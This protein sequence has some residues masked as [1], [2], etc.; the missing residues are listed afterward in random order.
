MLRPGPH[1]LGLDIGRDGRLLDE[2]GV[3]ARAIHVIGAA[4]RGVEW[5]VAAIPDIRRQAKSVAEALRVVP[6]DI[7]TLVG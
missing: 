7:G 4:R 1:G 3:P 5:E 2:A 6:S